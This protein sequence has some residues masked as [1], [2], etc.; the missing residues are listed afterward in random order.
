MPTILDFL[1][2]EIP[3]R[4][5]GRSF[6]GILTNEPYLAREQAFSEA[7]KPSSAVFEKNTDW[8]NERK[9]RSLRTSEER[10]IYRPR[11]KRSSLYRF[12]GGYFEGKDL[13]RNNVEQADKSA[14]EG[15]LDD[16]QSWHSEAKPASAE[17][18][19]SAE[20]AKMLE[21]LGYVDDEPTAEE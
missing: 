12:D 14:A 19:K 1:G 17:E 21:A 11:T 2:I 16:L 18:D 5:E 10:L 8:R 13:L 9:H 3:Q 20:S 4:V 15:L 7:T 6:A